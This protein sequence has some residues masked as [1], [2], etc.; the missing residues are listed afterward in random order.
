MGNLC[1]TICYNQ[2]IPI[3]KWGFKVGQNEDTLMGDACCVCANGSLHT[4]SGVF[5]A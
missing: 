1:E 4:A 3:V 2:T 5:W